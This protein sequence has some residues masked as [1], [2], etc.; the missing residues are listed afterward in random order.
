MF[1][2]LWHCRIIWY[3]FVS[4]KTI[5]LCSVHSV[6]FVKMCFLLKYGSWK[7]QLKSWNTNHES[8]NWTLYKTYNNKSCNVCS[9]I[10]NI[11]HKTFISVLMLIF[12]PWIEAQQGPP[13]TS[14]MESFAT[15]L[16]LYFVIC[17]LFFWKNVIP[18]YIIEKTLSHNPII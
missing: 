11:H 17:M 1:L 16:W 6:R 14:K 15:T 8:L 7:P 2:K 9:L 18:Y 4:F 3:L 12:L 10:N 13:Q 5:I